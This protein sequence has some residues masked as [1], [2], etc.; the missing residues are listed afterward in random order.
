MQ[1]TKYAS[2]YTERETRVEEMSQRMTNDGV[3]VEVHGTSEKTL[4]S[5]SHDKRNG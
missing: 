4:Q 1:A 3:L 2:I 5:K